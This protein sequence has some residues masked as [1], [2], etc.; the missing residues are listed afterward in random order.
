MPRR[1]VRIRIQFVKIRPI[2]SHSEICFRTIP[3]QSEKPFESRL[4]H[5]G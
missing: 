2:L 4:M 5:F 1:N 3:Y